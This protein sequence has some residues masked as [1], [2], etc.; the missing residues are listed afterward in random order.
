MHFAEGIQH[1]TYLERAVEQPFAARQ[2]CEDA[3]E[4]YE[5]PGRHTKVQQR[6]AAALLHVLQHALAR[7]QRRNHITCTFVGKPCCQG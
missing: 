5:A 2:A 7:L 6:A 4:A 3:L 1:S